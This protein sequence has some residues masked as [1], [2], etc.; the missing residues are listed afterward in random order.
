[1]LNWHGLA[2]TSE[3]RCDV[4]LDAAYAWSEGCDRGLTIS[5]I[6]RRASVMAVVQMLSRNSLPALDSLQPLLA[7]LP[8]HFAACIACPEWTLF[9]VDKVSGYPVFYSTEN[10]L[11][12]IS[13]SAR[14]LAKGIT[15]TQVNVEA[16]KEFRMAGYVTGSET[17]VHGVS[18]LQAGEAGLFGPSGLRRQRYFEF[19]S[20][21]VRQT[22]E[23]A[24]ISELEEIT[25]AVFDRLIE[26]SHGR[27]IV[28]PLSGGLD[29][30]IV[31]CKL[32]ER[33]ARDVQAFSYGSPGNH[34]ALVAKDVAARLGIAW[35]FV[36]T[37]R[38]EVLAM[39]S[40]EERRRYW[41]YADHLHLVPSLHAFYALATM[42]RK[43]RFSG[44]PVMVNGQSGDFICGNHIPD[45]PDG[46]VSHDRFIRAIATKHYSH[47]R[48]SC[49]ENHWP[50]FV[51]GRVR[52]VLASKPHLAAL[53]DLAKQIELWEWQARQS[54][55][56]INGQRN[57]D[58]FGLNWELPLWE[59]EYLDYFR[60]LPLEHKFGRRLF[61]RWLD[62][63]DF[64]GLFKHY[65]PFASRWPEGR[66]WILVVGRAITAALGRDVSAKWYSALDCFSQYDYLY[67]PFGY[68]GYWKG[69]RDTGSTIG[70][71][72]RAWES[73]NQDLLSRGTHP[74]N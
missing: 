32:K 36:P 44:D 55:R 26:E 25:N 70:F 9:F 66:G 15:N 20:H 43:G 34:D 12:T 59:V 53:Q 68:I 38:R 56:V 71:M 35:E 57:Y 27:R 50:D 29:S 1:M 61:R 19:Y 73:E 13:N 47:S 23:S 60:D 69:L 18:K 22:T 58:F 40:G 8:G 52:K 6:G 24:L 3:P 51:A 41:Q 21:Q 33:G 63:H 31:L 62:H 45:I 2:V 72:A 4:R 65:S 46:E 17:L 42:R 67:A 5:H 54:I 10:G 16:L 49:A 11:L 64:Y 74:L 39:Y 7:S 48:L 30:R 28:V 14:L 37:S